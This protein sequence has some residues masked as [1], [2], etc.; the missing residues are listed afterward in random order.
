[1]AFRACRTNYAVFRDTMCEGLFGVTA[2]STPPRDLD[3]RFRFVAVDRGALATIE[4]RGS[5]DLRVERSAQRIA[6]GGTPPMWVLGVCLR[7]VEVNISAR[8]QEITET[9]GL[10]LMDSNT[11]HAGITP[12]A[13]RIGMVS[14]PEDVARG[15]ADTRLWGHGAIPPTPLGRILASYLISVFDTLDELDREDADQ[16]VATTIQL[17]A[18]SQLPARTAIERA[19]PSLRAVRRR[20]ILQ[21]VDAHIADPHLSPTWL[22]KR[23]GLSPRYVH[24]LF[25]DQERSLGATI[26]ERRLA[27]CRDAL[28]DA[29]NARSSITEIAFRFGFSSSSHFSRVFRQAFGI[30]PRDLRRSCK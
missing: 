24:A 6:A 4:N 22:A 21:L 1:M 15:V 3:M 25:D 5:E 7:G 19:Q 8:G 26:L 13:T 11:P 23:I 17:L 16:L 14:I 28:L 27:L 12:A 18:S 2:P 29:R 10:R 20:E 9:G 30:S